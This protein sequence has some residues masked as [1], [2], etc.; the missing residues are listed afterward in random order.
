MRIRRGKSSST[1]NIIPTDMNTPSTTSSSSSSIEVKQKKRRIKIWKYL[2]YPLFITIFF[3]SIQLNVQF[4]LNKSASLRHLLGSNHHHDMKNSK[5]K[6]NSHTTNDSIHPSSN[7]MTSHK[8]SFWST[9][10]NLTSSIINILTIDSYNPFRIIFNTQSKQQQQSK[11]KL[12]LHVGP[13]KMA[14]T[15]IQNTMIR[16]EHL[17]QQNGY[18]I[19]PM[20]PLGKILGQGNIDKI[21]HHPEWNKL[22][23][24]LNECFQNNQHVLLSSEFMGLISPQVWTT[25]LRPAFQRWNFI[26]LVGYRRYYEWLPSV[27][28]QMFRAKDRLE[29][30][31]SITDFVRTDLR[32]EILYTE[33]YLRHW[34]RLLLYDGEGLEDYH[35]D[36]E[37]GR[38]KNNRDGSTSSTSTMGS[39]HSPTVS[40]PRS[41]G[42][43]TSN[44]LDGTSSKE[45]DDT[46]HGITHDASNNKNNKEFN[47][48]IYNMHSNQNVLKTLYCKVLPQTHQTCKQYSNI[49]PPMANTGFSIDYDRLV[50]AASQQDKLHGL[51]KRDIEGKEVHVVAREM[52]QLWEGDWSKTI[53]DFPRDCLST[54]EL[55]ILF[56]KSMEWESLLV[57]DYFEEDVLQQLSKFEDEFYGMAKV[58]YCSVDVDKVVN[59]EEYAYLWNGLERKRNSV[60]L[61][62]LHEKF[63]YQWSR[64]HS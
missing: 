10:Y 29:D 2:L 47:Y 46:L 62:G 54:E 53:M 41:L 38:A 16:D 34:S 55:K 43:N 18:C 6:W 4:I 7:D 52:Q 44:P 61:K 48:L 45:P 28:F 26:L 21:K 51:K 50:I 57:P 30:I 37:H 42:D 27:Y 25:L 5:F 60:I 31:P 35:G 13:G 11:K 63:G 20:H 22:L 40:D 15:T 32:P 19:F 64:S 39:H 58:K 17:L 33:N 59:D 3:L 49:M 14:T 24:T 36:D 23:L 56:D 8:L 1:I 12:Y 9:F